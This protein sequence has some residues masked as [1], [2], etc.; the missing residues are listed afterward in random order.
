MAFRPFLIDVPACLLSWL[1][2]RR[3]RLLS[4]GPYG[5]DHRVG[6]VVVA[7]TFTRQLRNAVERRLPDIGH[8]PYFEDLTSA[9]QAI[10]YSLLLRTVDHAPR[11]ADLALC[12]SV[13]TVRQA[14]R[15][16]FRAIGAGCRCCWRA[17]ALVRLAREVRSSTGGSQATVPPDAYGRRAE[18]DTP[19][20]SSP[21]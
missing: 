9:S 12:R 8:D 11:A 3:R 13:L 20:V 17:R 4:R 16:R 1:R 19:L 5:C 6:G 10:E 14:S 18:S 15:A 2:P 7:R 21:R